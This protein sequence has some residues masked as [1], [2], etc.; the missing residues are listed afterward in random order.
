MVVSA[1]VL[2]ILA[3]VSYFM[4]LEIV[5]GLDRGDRW[6]W[7]KVVDTAIMTV[8]LLVLAAVSDANWATRASPPHTFGDPSEM[9]SSRCWVSS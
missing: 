6:S 9:I 4:W 1:I 3:V 5:L 2:L 7:K 8:G